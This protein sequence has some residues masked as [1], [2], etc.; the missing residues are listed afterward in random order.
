MSRAA[1]TTYC[2]RVM[3]VTLQCIEEVEKDKFEVNHQTLGQAKWFRF[4]TKWMGRELWWLGPSCPFAQQWYCVL[5]R[6]CCNEEC[7]K[8]IVFD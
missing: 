5:L 3:K 6:L 7:H 2:C 1:M 8:S 4:A